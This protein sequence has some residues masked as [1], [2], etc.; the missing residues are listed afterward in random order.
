[1]RNPITPDGRYFVV[2]GRLWRSANPALPAGERDRL[3]A[4]LMA[5]RRAVGWARRQGDADALAAARAA[6]DEAKRGLGM[7]INAVARELLMQGEREKFLTEQWPE[8]HATIQRLGL[9]GELLGKPKV[10]PLRRGE[11]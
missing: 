1:M 8:I 5:A 10:T 11:G 6:V 3:V 9:A 4:E 2:R 7:F